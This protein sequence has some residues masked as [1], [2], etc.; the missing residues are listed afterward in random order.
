MT[1]EICVMNQRGIALA[2]DSA[3]TIGGTRTF[4]NATKLF[5]MDSA[6]YVGVMI[7][8]NADIMHIPWEVIIK[9]FREKLQNEPL[10]SLHSYKDKLIEFI[11]N[12]K[13]LWQGTNSNDMILN[14]LSDLMDLIFKIYD[15]KVNSLNSEG[16]KINKNS[17]LK[18][19]IE[20][21]EIDKEDIFFE[22]PHN[23]FQA[24]T[25][26]LINNYVGN[27]ISQELQR[28][29]QDK[30]YDFIRSKNF[31]R[32]QTGIVIAG[33]GKDEL[34]P[35]LVQ[36][37]V[38]GLYNGK[39]KYTETSNTST[40]IVG[41]DARASLLPF[42][43][44]EM[45]HTIMTGI[46][47]NLDNFRIN[48]LSEL[49]QNLISVLGNKSS[50]IINNIFENNEKALAKYKEENISGPIISMLNNLSLD[51]LGTMAETFVSLTSFKRKFSGDLQ[52]VGGPIDVLVISKGEGPVWIK[53]KKYFDLDMNEGYQLRRR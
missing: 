27:E 25:V 13:E 35:R 37:D 3:V 31:S 48:Q 34:F 52:T 39:L 51:E 26:D 24:K 19:S 38:D 8:G 14:Y 40:S 43:Q 17:L 50:K 21:I 36:L 44:Q 16:K 30:L 49:Q 32:S 1:A 6:H 42:A 22:I 45:V 7:Y 33:Y 47:P 2:A 46:D 12:K 23:E 53:R 10:V 5:T 15:N 9:G 11:E 20:S 29:I 18:E 41:G 4:N 28:L